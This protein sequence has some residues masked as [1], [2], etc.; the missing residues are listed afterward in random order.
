MSDDYGPFALTKFPDCKQCQ[1][2]YEVH[3]RSCW[4]RE[5]IL[6]AAM[7]KKEPWFEKHWKQLIQLILF[8]EKKLAKDELLLAEIKYLSLMVFSS[9]LGKDDPYLKI[10]GLSRQRDKY[11][12]Q[13]E[14]VQYSSA[15]LN[16]RMRQELLQPLKEDIVRIIVEFWEE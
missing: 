13:K 16:T 4:A 11:F 2:D 1:Q 5:V 12:T 8:L 3:T 9:I 10:R 7:G 15:Q 6:H 14:F